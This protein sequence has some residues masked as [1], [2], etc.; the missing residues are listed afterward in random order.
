MDIDRVFKV[1]SLPTG[2]K[3][4]LEPSGEDILKKFRTEEYG[5]QQNKFKATVEDEH[6]SMDGDDQENASYA[7]GNDPDYFAEEDEDGRFFG[8]GLTSEQKEILNIFDHA[9]NSAAQG[10]GRQPSYCI[11][12]A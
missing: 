9:P 6:E 1:P 12:I 3:R 2:K 10:T 7:P 4:R 8:G 5:S 11:S